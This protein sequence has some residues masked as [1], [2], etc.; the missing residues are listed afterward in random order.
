[1]VFSVT[2]QMFES[3]EKLDNIL[4]K[5]STLSFNKDGGDKKALAREGLRGSGAGAT[6]GL[7]AGET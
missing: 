3:S 5:L 1:M 4:I 2:I 6:I 7:T